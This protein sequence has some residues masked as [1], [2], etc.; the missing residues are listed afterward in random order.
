[1]KKEK[2]CGIYK[3]TSPTKRVYIG[4]SKD[5]K[6]RWKSY[7]RKN[8]NQKLLNNSLLKYGYENHTF[9]IIEECEV[10]DLNCRERY[11]QD[12]YD[13]L[14]GGL[15]CKLT[16]CGEDRVIYSDDLKILISKQRIESGIAKGGNNGNAKKVIN[17]NTGEILSC[18]KDL[19][20]KIGM[21]Y[22]SLIYMLNG[23]NYNSTEWCFLDDYF[24]EIYKENIKPDKIDKG[25]MIICTKTLKT[26]RSITLCALDIN[27]KPS[28][29]MRYLNPNNDRKNP[30]TFQRL[31][32]YI[33]DNPDFN[34]DL[35]ID[36]DIPL[37]EVIKLNSGIVKDNNEIGVVYQHRTKSWMYITKINNK[38][39]QIGGFC[40]KDDAIEIKKLAEL[41]IKLYENNKQF[42]K[43]I[44][45]KYAYTTT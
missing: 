15:N 18:G 4:Q 1:M 25:E 11:W 38:K 12:F 42:R 20:K 44:K 40:K 26:W 2:I 22:S 37:D 29:L 8:Q 16:N 17:Y 19:S 32:I 31:S 33:N 35:I 7:K 27:I 6:S 24:T 30:T 39:F 5:I 41:N 14:N 23:Q 10:E 34:Y 3:I 45:L 28:Q 13:V 43:L 9:E 36:D 21:K